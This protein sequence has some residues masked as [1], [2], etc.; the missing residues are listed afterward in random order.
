MAATGREVMKAENSLA[1]F[2]LKAS[3][4][5]L[6]LITV[7]GGSS[8][9][10]SLTLELFLNVTQAMEAFCHHAEFTHRTPKHD[11]GKE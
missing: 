5:Q 3:S 11:T 4:R 2:F 1:F 6:D 9:K 7:E 10:L 8:E